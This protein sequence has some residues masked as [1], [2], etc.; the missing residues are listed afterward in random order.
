MFNRKKKQEE[1][2]Q[3][4]I[5]ETNKE[6]EMPKQEVKPEEQIPNEFKETLDSMRDIYGFIEPLNVGEY[7][8][9]NLLLGIYHELRELNKKVKAE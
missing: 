7:M 3:T 2:V 9:C 1:K 6:P 4:G 8:V 5:Q